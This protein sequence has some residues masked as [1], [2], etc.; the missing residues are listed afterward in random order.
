VAIIPTII[1]TITPKCLTTMHTIREKLRTLVLRG[2][3]TAVSTASKN[4]CY[5]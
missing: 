2:K 4:L 1:H 3:R 5:S